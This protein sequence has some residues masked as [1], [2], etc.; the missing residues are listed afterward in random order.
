[1]PGRVGSRRLFDRLARSSHRGRGLAVRVQFC[2]AD[3]PEEIAV[4]YAIGRDVGGAVVRNR[5]RRRMRA[6]MDEL[7][8]AL[9][10]GIYLIKCD[11]RVC[12][13]SP[14]Q[15]RADLERALTGAR[16]LR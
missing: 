13:L 12:D 16:A 10:P 11:F 2:P 7:T 9:S 4:A 6:L 15:L 5:Q 3:P 14:T 8:P 1:V